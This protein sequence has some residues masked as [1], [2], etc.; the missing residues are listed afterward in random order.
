LRRH[1]T[2]VLDSCVFVY[3]LEENPRYLP[4]TDLIFSWLQRPE[5]AAIASTIAMMELLVQPYRD[6]D[7]S[8]VDGCFALLSKFPNLAW[9][10]PSMEIAD[11]A[12]SLR[13]EHR[14]KTPDAII[15]AT[16]V[17]SGAK[18]LI[19]NDTSFRRVESIDTLLLNA[20]L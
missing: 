17:V 3:Q 5:S 6:K 13:A 19:T 16:A 10:P 4:L 12:A 18:A 15:A 1:G 20:H 14:L 9:A 2:V 11:V 7:I 8:R